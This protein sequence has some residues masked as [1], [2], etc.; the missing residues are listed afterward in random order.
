MT[1][2]ITCKQNIQTHHIK[3][4]KMKKGA[5]GIDRNCENP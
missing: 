2:A 5:E 4:L 3:H 1:K